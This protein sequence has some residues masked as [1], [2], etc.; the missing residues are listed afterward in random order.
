MKLLNTAQSRRTV[1]GLLAA[2]VATRHLPVHADSRPEVI[3]NKDPNCGC[4]QK[5]ADHLTHAGFPVKTIATD[6]LAAIKQRLGVPE[7]LASCHT[8]QVAGYVLEGHVPAIAVVRL[9]AEK[10]I[11]TGLAVAGMPIGSPGMEGGTPED[12]EVVLFGPSVRRVYA[13]FRGEREI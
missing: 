8:A 11:A 2:T 7:D 4:C 1:L 10:P 5:W 9:L 6:R 13:R 12:Y 3:V